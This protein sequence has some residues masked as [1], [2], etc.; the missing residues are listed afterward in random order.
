MVT[1]H[2]QSVFVYTN[3]TI[4][5]NHALQSLFPYFLTCSVSLAL[6]QLCFVSEALNKHKKDLYTELCIPIYLKCRIKISTDGRKVVTT[7]MTEAL[8]QLD[9]SIFLSFNQD[10]NRFHAGEVLPALRSKGKNNL[11]DEKGVFGRVCRHDFPKSL[12]SIK[13][14]ER[15]DFKFEFYVHLNLCMLG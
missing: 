12:L 15:L 9:S 6:Q 10:C 4:Q 7:C 5:L 14:G 13:Y 1:Y 3:C 8:S 2:F 11:F